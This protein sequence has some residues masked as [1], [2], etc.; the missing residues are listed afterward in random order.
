MVKKLIT[1]MVVASLF[2][3]LVVP[4]V[5]AQSEAPKENVIIIF[6]ENIDQKAVQSVDG[7]IDAV[8]LN[9][10]V[11]TGEIPIDAIDDLKKDRDVLAVEID[12]RI[13]MSGQVQDW[14]ISTIK[15][16][17]AWTSGYTGSGMK[18]AVL[19]TGIAPHLDLQ[20]AG[21]I[22]FTSYTPSYFDDN[23]H[24]THV[25]GIIGAE[26]NNI[27]VVGVAPDADI[28]AV[29]VLDKNGSG[30]LSD[31]IKGIDWAIS[32]RMDIINLSLGTQI[33]SFVLKQAV[34]KA[35]NN[36][37][38]VVA[39]A[40]ND[41]NAE[42]IG[43]TVDFPARYDSVIGVS[44]VDKLNN[45]GSFSSTGEE[46]EIAAPGVKVYSTYLNN[47]Y[48]IMNGTSM[49]APFVAGT[50]ALLKQANPSLTNI[51]LREKLKES[52]TD[53]GAVGKDSFFG[54]GLV[55]TNIQASRSLI[56]N[57]PMATE[58]PTSGTTEPLQVQPTPE[59]APV[60]D[61][62]PQPAPSPV[63]EPKPESNPVQKPVQNPAA[64]QPKPAPKKTMNATIKTSASKYKG[65]N[66]VYIYL[67]AVD[68]NTKKT[69]A[70]GKLK[71]TIRSPKGQLTTYTVKTNSKGSTLVKWKVPK[72]AVKGNYQLKLSA[73][74][75]SY[76]QG[77][78]SKTVRIY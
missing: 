44:A 11:V 19:D 67:S 73:T 40:G 65:G 57:E 66:Y 26:N 63:I 52:A 31:I 76:N 46:V 24:G 61:S 55:Q 69:I 58:I 42:G 70:G 36:G 45:R 1:L 60:Q 35:Y 4:I 10:P 39:A 28:Y 18:I 56:D 71:V 22:S 5:Q 29:K 2:F 72:Y 49:A 54:Y 27:G 30:N 47:N 20:V 53:I 14:G 48:A 34:D 23:G 75:T 12:K 74:A 15:A 33:H 21:G 37:I 78:A 17:S 25:A 77:S 38:L 62:V 64:V 6:K 3:S 7:E 43:E 50:L 68:K 32:N 51:Q 41:G 59:L 16:Q 13:Q 8:L 9:V